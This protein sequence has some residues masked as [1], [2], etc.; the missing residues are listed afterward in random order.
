MQLWRYS[1]LRF[2]SFLPLCCDPLIFFDFLSIFSFDLDPFDFWPFPFFSLLTPLLSLFFLILLQ[3][4]FSKTLDLF[5]FPY[6]HTYPVFFSISVPWPC[7]FTPSISVS[8]SVF[9]YLSPFVSPFSTWSLQ[10]PFEPL[11]SRWIHDNNF[12]TSFFDPSLLCV[13]G[14]H[15]LT[16]YN[17]WIDRVLGSNL[18]HSLLLRSSIPPCICQV[19]S[20]RRIFIYFVIFWVP[21]CLRT[22]APYLQTSV[23]GFVLVQQ[24]CSHFPGASI[25]I[26]HPE[27]SISSLSNSISDGCPGPLVNPHMSHSTTLSFFLPCFCMFRLF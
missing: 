25:W 4:P 8:I 17:L 26:P 11:T 9:C 23:Y 6:F 13:P 19:F 5:C 18:F 16:H 7:P 15:L 22:S 24:S 14:Y 1:A 21:W 2:Y 12:V 20:L 27:P 10:L 3:S